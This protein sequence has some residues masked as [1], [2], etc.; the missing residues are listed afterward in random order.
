MAD[1]ASPAARAPLPLGRKLLYATLATGLALAF[2]LGGLELGLRLC[3]YGHSAHFARREKLADGTVVWRDNR[4]FTVPFFSEALARRPQ[5]FRLAEKKA[6]G[7][8]RIFVL[9]SSAAT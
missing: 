7:A 5:S 9:G 1:T 4:D 2:L 8:I 3:G 6:P